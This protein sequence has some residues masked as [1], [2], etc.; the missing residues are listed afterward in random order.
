MNTTTTYRQKDS[1]WQIIVSWKDANGKWHQKSKQGFAKKTDAKAYE[2]ELLKQIKNRPQPVDK[3]MTGITLLQFCETYTKLKKSI[4]ENTKLQYTHAVKSLGA[5]A[6]KP[7]HQI[8]CLD[9]QSAVSDWNMVPM[10][11]KMYK[12]KLD[13]LFRAAMRPYGLIAT[14]PMTDIEI[15]KSRDVTE[16]ITLSEEQFAK[17][18]KIS[19]SSVRIAAA[20]CYYTGIRRGEM[21]ALT[22]KDIDFPRME[23]TINKQFDIRRNKVTQPKSKNGYRTIPIP[24]ALLQMLKQY[25]DTQPLSIDRRVFRHPHGVYESL[26]TKMKRVGSRLSPHCLRH[27][28]ATRL[29]ARGID[30]RTVA[31]LLGDDTKT[32]INTYVH[33]SDEMRAAAARDIQ[34]IFAQNF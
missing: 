14:N 7:V 34:K 6:K 17:L 15:E 22:W 27:T 11:Q 28:Y 13:I 16:R 2:H 19:K 10:T 33:Y 4:S 25:H 24:Q 9:I 3:A 26:A 32:V 12:N 20:I 18:L 21:L 29:L 23:L 31:A 1:G 30:I 5:L 8:T